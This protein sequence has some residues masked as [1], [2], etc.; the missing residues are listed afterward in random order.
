MD[1]R[2]I[3]GENIKKF[4]LHYLLTQ[5]DLAR[6]SGLSQGYL[7]Q[8]ES[9]KRK[10]TQKSLEIISRTLGI[11]IIEFFRESG[12]AL[13]QGEKKS[14]HFGR[15]YTLRKEFLDLLAELPLPIVEHYLALLKMEKSLLDKEDALPEGNKR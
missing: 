13:P 5:K 2:T 11:P 10:Y 9:G 6:L 3:V 7:N 15:E 14:G 12:R 1:T 8:L 4:R